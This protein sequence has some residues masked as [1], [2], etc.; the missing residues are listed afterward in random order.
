MK[1]R[2]QLYYFRHLCLS[3]NMFY[4]M[5]ISSWWRRWN[6]RESVAKDNSYRSTKLTNGVGEPACLITEKMKCQGGWNHKKLGSSLR[7]FLCAEKKNNNNN[8]Q[9]LHSALRFVLAGSIFMLPDL[10]IPFGFF[11]LSSSFTFQ[12]SCRPWNSF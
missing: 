5:V 8:H 9:H 12:V 2:I 4:F 10:L 3:Q 11:Q 7:D 1:H 6:V